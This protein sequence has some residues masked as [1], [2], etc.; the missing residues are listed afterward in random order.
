MSAAC[1]P[2]WHLKSLV[3]QGK[4]PVKSSSFLSQL[5]IKLQGRTFVSAFQ[6]LQSLPMAAVHQPRSAG[7]PCSVLSGYWF[8]SRAGKDAGLDLKCSHAAGAQMRGPSGMCTPRDAVVHLG[9][10][11]HMRAR[12]E[13]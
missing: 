10:G 7:A 3:S 2:G 12:M 8:L 5:M 13:S 4:S 6:E 9:D 1:K 11:Q